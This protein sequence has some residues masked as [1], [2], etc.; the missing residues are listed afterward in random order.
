MNFSYNFRQAFPKHL[1][2]YIPNEYQRQPTWIDNF[3]NDLL[4][5]SM[6]CITLRQIKD[7][8]LFVNYRY[9]PRHPFP[10]WYT[11]PNPEESRR[12]WA[13]FRFLSF[14]LS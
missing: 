4:M 2:H 8:E 11:D 13:P 5:P 10:G 7:E 14:D 1:Q 6:L 3:E 9:N 12:R